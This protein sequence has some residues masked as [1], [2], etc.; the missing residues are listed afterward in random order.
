MSITCHKIKFFQDLGLLYVPGF[1]TN[2]ND[3]TNT[4]VQTC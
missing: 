4:S 1:I 3:L 2:E